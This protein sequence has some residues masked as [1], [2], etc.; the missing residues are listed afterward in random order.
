[1]SMADGTNVPYRTSPSF[2]SLPS[3]GEISGGIDPAFNIAPCG[4]VTQ[5]AFLLIQGSE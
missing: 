1:M 5:G 2:V 3:G 4:H